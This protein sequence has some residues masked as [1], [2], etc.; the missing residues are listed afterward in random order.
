MQCNTAVL[1]RETFPGIS[2]ID[3]PKDTFSFNAIRIMLLYRSS[4]LSHNILYYIGNLL[5]E[6]HIIDIV[7]GDFNIDIMD[8]TNIKLQHLLF[9]YTL[10]VN[11]ATDNLVL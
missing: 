8:S 4:S 1:K 9:Y 2:V 6:S 11:E 5:S 3:I 7:L 10:L